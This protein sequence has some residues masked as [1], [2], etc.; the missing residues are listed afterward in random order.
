MEKL[1]AQLYSIQSIDQIN[2]Y[3]TQ[4]GVC[5]KKLADG[6]LAW[7]CMDC[8]NDPGGI[9]CAECFENSQHKGHRVILKRNVHG[10]CDCGDADSWDENN[11]CSNHAG[12][13]MNAK[14]AIERLPK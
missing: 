5:A 4:R 7:R 14:D 13:E 10:C 6:D 8:E 11:F 3:N 9:L 2:K 1:K 12:R